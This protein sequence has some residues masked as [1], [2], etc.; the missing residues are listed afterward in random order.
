VRARARIGIAA[1]LA[2]AISFA[3][4]GVASGGGSDKKAPDAP[5]VRLTSVAALPKLA[6]DPALVQARERARRERRAQ[7]A[8]H[9]RLVLARR[10][11][12]R[13][14]AREA[15]AQPPAPQPTPADTT[16]T[17]PATPVATPPPA[18]APAPTPA[19]APKPQPP[20]QTFDN[21]G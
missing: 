8:R 19:P 16:P 6:E 4:A 12:A 20:P 7:R 5:A 1:L 17:T 14:A 18:P 15:A 21:S 2:F 11:A 3:I 13:R 10:A 9:H